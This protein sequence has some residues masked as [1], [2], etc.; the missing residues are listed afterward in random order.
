MRP[1]EANFF[2]S[3]PHAGELVPPEV[4]WLSNIS[5]TTL[6]RDVDRFVDKIYQPVISQLALNYVNT[7]WHR[8]VV[9]LNRK[10]DEF[11]S[12]AVEGA[13]C[14]SGTHPKGLHWVVTTWGESLITK[15]MTK[16]VHNKLIQNCYMPFHSQ[17]KKI[18]EELRIK[19][20]VF[21][22]DAHS[23]PSRGTALHNDPGGDRADIV[24]SDFHGKSSCLSF[25]NL[26]L[27][28]YEMAG[29]KCAYNFP[30]VGGG[31]TQMYGEPEK[32]F[33]TIQIELNRKLYMNEDSKELLPIKF[34]ETQKKIA[35]A[36]SMIHKN[37]PNIPEAKNEV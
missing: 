3:I 15:P 12:S 24:V 11:D 36:I 27:Q 21:H 33:H 8:Y 32:G 28:S 31:I 17:I 18:R 20:H 14:P 5:F 30:Y 26:V 34:H 10:L 25:K 23:M 13:I 6:M 16:E 9:D 7:D 22:I 29:F 1:M 35:Q 4:N 2:I 19:G 37:I